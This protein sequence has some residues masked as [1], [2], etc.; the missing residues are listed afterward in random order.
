MPDGERP[1][2]RPIWAAGSAHAAVLVVI[3]DSDV[4]RFDAGL[5]A[6]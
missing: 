3:E 6:R 1:V 4:A 5:N 2:R